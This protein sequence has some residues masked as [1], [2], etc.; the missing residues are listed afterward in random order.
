MFTK[1]RFCVI[2]WAWLP[3]L[4]HNGHWRYKQMFSHWFLRM[5]S[6]YI[7]FFSSAFCILLMGSKSSLGMNWAINMITTNIHE[8]IIKLITT[9]SWKIWSKTIFRDICNNL[10]VFPLQVSNE[11]QVPAFSTQQNDISQNYS[12]SVFKNV[13][14][15][16][17]RAVTFVAKVC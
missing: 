9:F 4:E 11:Y 1:S 7:I 8:K 10:L 16:K 17:K 3:L 5:C 6:L 13:F 15:D 14:F 2:N 12:Y